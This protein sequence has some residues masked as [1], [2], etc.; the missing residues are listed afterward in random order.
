MAPFQNPCF[1]NSRM[2]RVTF[3]PFSRDVYSSKMP[4]ICRIISWVGSSPVGC[5]TDTT[6]TPCLRRL[7]IVE[8]HLG[9]VSI[10]TG[11]CVHHND[12][13][14]AI[15]VA[16]GFHHPLEDGAPVIG[17]GCARLD[18][19]VDDGPAVRLAVRTRELPL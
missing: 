16:S 13:E 2:A 4:I 9:A 1:A 19:L 7:R 18:I 6:S 11:K 12:V 14:W 8:L 5:V 17:G 3:F 15:R 10:K